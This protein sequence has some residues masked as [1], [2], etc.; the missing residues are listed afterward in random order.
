VVKVEEKGAALLLPVAGEGLRPLVTGAAAAATGVSL[1]RLGLFFLKI[2]AVLYGSGY[3][4]VAFLENE[5]VNELGWLSQTQL[6]DAIAMGQF[7]PGPVLST[8][9]F[10]GFIIGGPPGAAV[11][12]LGIFLPSFIFVLILNPIIPRLRQNVW[13]AAF[14][15]AVNVSAVAL[16]IAVTIMLGRETLVSWQ[17][18][19]VALLATAA[20]FGLR[21]NSAWIILGGAV[22]GYGLHLI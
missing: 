19:L 6:L 18:W 20:A 12:T 2:G 7:T 11:S 14:L 21:L 15:D 5:L 8:A 13:A 22:L 9:A 4:L 1:W 3:V 17:A 10:I 16:M